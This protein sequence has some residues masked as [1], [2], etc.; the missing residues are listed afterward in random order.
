[1]ASPYVEDNGVALVLR[2]PLPITGHVDVSAHASVVDDEPSVLVKELQKLDWRPVLN[3]GF[4]GLCCIRCPGHAPGH[5]PFGRGP[6]FREH[7]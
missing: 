2:A 6:R 7:L 4:L 5:E 3:G 1:M